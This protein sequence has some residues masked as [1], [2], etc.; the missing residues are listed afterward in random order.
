MQKQDLSARRFTTSAIH[1][2]EQL[3]PRAADRSMAS[4]VT[5]SS[6]TMLTL[7]SLLRWERKVGIV[8]LERMGVEVD[9]L[10]RDVDR[11][12]SAECEE[13]ARLAGEPE[14]RALPSGRPAVVVDFDRPLEP[15]LATAEHE[16]MDL[17]HTWVGTEHLL[18]A[19]VRLA[20]PR[21]RELLDRHGIGYEGLQRAVLDVLRS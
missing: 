11:A 21:L 7:W 3:G 5:P 17:G 9:A 20:G 8:A 18:L 14:W 12:L 4:A 1:I 16:A 6:L 19:T 13:I 10:A 15:I 2:I